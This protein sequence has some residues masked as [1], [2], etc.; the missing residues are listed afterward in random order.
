VAERQKDIQYSSRTRMVTTTM[1]EEQEFRRLLHEAIAHVPEAHRNEPWYERAAKVACL[2]RRNVIHLIYRDKPYE[3]Y[4]KDYQFGL[5][6]MN[7][8]WSSGLSDMR[9]TLEHRE[10]LEMPSEQRP[11]VT[12]DLQGPHRR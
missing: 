4:A 9:S 10:W 3:S 7:E 6:T 11:F 8:H 1:R 12:H 5:V 2:A